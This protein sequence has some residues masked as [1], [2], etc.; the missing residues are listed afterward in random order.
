MADLGQAYVQIIPKAEGISGGIEKVLSS[1]A[2][3]AGTK[4]GGLITG[5]IN[6][7]VSGAGK[8]FAPIAGGLAA[9]LSIKGIT[10]AFSDVHEGLENIIKKTGAS[11]DALTGMRDILSSLTSSIPVDFATAGDAI[12]EVNTRFGLT[13]QALE[14]LSGQFLKFADLNDTDVTTSIDQT[15]KA[16]AAFGMDAKDAG[17]LL[18]TL[19]KVGQNTGASVDTLTAGLIQ[20]GTAFQQMGLSIDDAAVFMGKLETSGANSES[21]MQGLRRALKNATADGTSMTDALDQLQTSI[22][23][24]KDGVDGLTLAYDLF[25][26]SGD[27]IYGAI[28]NGTIDFTNLAG[29]AEDAGGS[30]TDT[31]NNTLTPADKFREVINKLK[32]VLVTLADTVIEK[33][34]PIFDKIKEVWEQIRPNVEALWEAVKNLGQAFAD[35]VGNMVGIKDE[36]AATDAA[37]S[38]LKTVI[39]GATTVVQ[40][41]ADHMDVLVPI[42][43]GV[44]I[45]ILGVNAAMWV[46][47]ANPIILIIAGIIAA[48]TALIM[49]WDKLKAT[50]VKNWNI[51]KNSALTIWNAIKNT[52]ISVWNAMKQTI[53]TV[54][55][56]IRNV[57][58]KV[59]NGLKTA[60]STIWNGNKTAVTTPI[61]A[62]KNFISTAF[63][64][65]KNTATRIWNGIKEAITKPIT[66]ARDTVHN[67]IE[68]IKGFFHFNWSLPHLKL[69]HFG[70]SPAGWKFGDLLKGSIPKL[71]INWY[72]E[73]GIVDGATILGA[74]EA[75]PEGI[76]PLS[77]SAMRPFAR[78]IAEEMPNGGNA[79]TVNLN[80]NASDDAVDLLRG[81][82]RGVNR[83]RRAGAF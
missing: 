47:S 50:V 69:P 10:S 15:Q 6:K 81:L 52:V 30:V 24:G 53:S 55:N 35:T 71:S 21:V 38:G 43:G 40:F 54:I 29:A 26:R 27:Q 73:G 62:V 16:L 79:I 83:Y 51:L 2:S 9:A 56:A 61:N 68:K 75:G 80:Y 39:D 11:G 7:S 36:A 78:A 59:W 74:G 72:A 63:N 42:L 17:S 45:A 60:A 5:G 14:D 25:G 31:F 65:I 23:N 20:N 77:G 49:N 33:V 34:K 3:S 8:L 46:M 19:N 66:S 64:A 12:G 57:V 67:I 4:A 13:G 18:D 28:Q 22:L 44:A 32:D 82:V 58:M 37:V 48:I 1:E 70:I 41:L 76:I